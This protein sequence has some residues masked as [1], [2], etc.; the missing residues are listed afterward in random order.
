MTDEQLEK[1]TQAICASLGPV[2]GRLL[3]EGYEASADAVM[4]AGVLLQSLARRVIT[5]EKLVEAGNVLANTAEA[6]WGAISGWD[7]A[8]EAYREASK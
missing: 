6:G 5:A 4:E 3:T 2:H 1:Q 8:V 7:E